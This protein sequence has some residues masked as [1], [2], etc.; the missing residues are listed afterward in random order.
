MEAYSPRSPS[1]SQ[2]LAAPRW[3]NVGKVGITHLIDGIDSALI[4]T[5]I[6]GTCEFN[7]FF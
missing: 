5:V 2:N 3:G 7:E 4:V 1:H 6:A